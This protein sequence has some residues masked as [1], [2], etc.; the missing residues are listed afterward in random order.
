MDLPTRTA[1]PALAVC[2]ALHCLSVPAFPSEERLAPRM[3]L[4]MDFKQKESRFRLD[5]RKKCFPVRVVR[6][7]HLD[8]PEQL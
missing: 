8:D 3:D 6:P 2:R 7:W 1:V 4:G 5:I